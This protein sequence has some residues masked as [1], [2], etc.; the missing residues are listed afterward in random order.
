MA[1]KVTHKYT[2]AGGKKTEVL[3]FLEEL[4]GM[5][6]HSWIPIEEMSESNRATLTPRQAGW[7]ANQVERRVEGRSIAFE[8][9][10]EP[11]EA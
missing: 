8:A 5:P 4:Q 7:I 11:A 3:S 10:E 1:S 9:I 6:Q 2:V